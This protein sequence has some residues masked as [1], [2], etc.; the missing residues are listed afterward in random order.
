MGE[1]VYAALANDG[2]VLGDAAAAL[3]RALGKDTTRGEAH[4]LL[5]VAYQQLG[6][7]DDAIRE[8]ERSVRI[9]SAR[10]D[11]LRALAQAYQR[12]NRPA[13]AISHLYER[14]LGVQPALAWIR[15]EYADFLQAE[16]RREAAESAYR[17]ALAE[18]PG[19]AVAWFNLGT[20][21]AEAGRLDESSA[22]FR[23]AVQL[24]PSL[25]QA[26]SELLEIRTTGKAVT[27][28]RS[29]GSPLPSLP[30]R[31]RGPGA[32]E[33]T[34]AAGGGPRVLF[35]N[36]PPHD[37]V[38]ILKPDGTVV[39]ALPTGAGTDQSWDLMTEA[40]NPIGGGVYRA[41]VQGRDASGRPLPPRVLYFGIVRQRVE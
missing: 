3:H 13:A 41:R 7:N 34:V 33:L 2:R 1:I 4:F 17:S 31:E 9:D 21:L 15:A 27:G 39:R 5:G 28:V 10:P 30:L 36:V 19:L 23:S 26:L 11:R 20:V 18:Q 29:L 35:L 14:A 12:A 22:A 6:R 25:A 24:D 32:L 38:R 16:G 8:L 37:M 40:G